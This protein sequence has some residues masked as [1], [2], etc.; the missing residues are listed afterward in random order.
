MRNNRVKRVLDVSVAAL[1]S[2]YTIYEK[3]LK[4]ELTVTFFASFLFLAFIAA[5]AVIDNYCHKLHTFESLFCLVIAAVM[6]IGDSFKNYGSFYM[7]CGNP[8]SDAVLDSLFEGFGKNLSIL[9]GKIG[10]AIMM[11]AS[12]ARFGGYFCILSLFLKALHAVC[13][14]KWGESVLSPLADKLCRGKIYWKVFFVLAIAWLPFLI[15]NAPGFVSRDASWQINQF[16]GMT[17]YTTHHPVFSTWCIGVLVWLGQ[18][19]VSYK[20]G[21]FLFVL[22]QYVTLDFIL[23]YCIFTVSQWKVS[24]LYVLFI[25]LTCAIIP[26]FGTMVTS[27]IKDTMYCALFALYILQ[28][29]SFLREHRAGDVPMKRLIWIAVLSLLVSLGRNN[30]IYCV[31]PTD[32]L[33]ICVLLFGKNKKQRWQKTGLIL[34]SFVLFFGFNVFQS[35]VLHVTKGSVAEALSLPFQQTARFVTEY[36]GDVLPEER[37]IIDKVLDYD[38]L[39]DNYN[40]LCSDNVKA[41]Y[42]GDNSALL[43]YFKVWFKQFFRHPL[44]YLSATIHQTYPA[45]YPDHS[46]TRSY[47]PFSASDNKDVPLSGFPIGQVLIMGYAMGL[48]LIPVVSWWVNPVMYIW[49]FILMLFGSWGRK[50]RLEWLIWLPCIIHLLTVIAGPAIINHP[51]YLYPVSWSVLWIGA[52]VLERKREQVTNETH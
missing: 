3:I 47:A 11:V 23:T 9:Q 26:C 48:S 13:E 50:E 22:V 5:Y 34:L 20:F 30:G 10:N 44:C 17:G 16:M 4:P 8:F 14:K 37:E 15:I 28:L 33:L 41:T 12:L 36:P 18:T 52:Y 27:V 46:N 21:L 51:R 45:F 6:V 32:V 1:L 29:L 31:I 7:I 2:T 25:T 42:R 49:A 38:H 19:L 35:R 39:S 24:R 43:A 40:P